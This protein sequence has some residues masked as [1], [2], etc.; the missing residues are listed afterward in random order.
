MVSPAIAPS[1]GVKRS[2][3][4]ADHSH[5]SSAKLKNAWS[6]TSTP[7]TRLHGVV[8]SESTGTTLPFILRM[9]L[10]VILYEY[11][12]VLHSKERNQIENIWKRSS[13]ENI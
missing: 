7:P 6:C 3:C 12:T 9:V 2:G 13:E 11:E 1:L 10:P 5:P 4:E 8:L